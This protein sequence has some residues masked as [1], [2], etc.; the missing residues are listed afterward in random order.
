MRVVAF[1][2]SPRKEG[3]TALALGTV[4]AELEAAGI[5][6]ELVQVGGRRV[7]GCRA[8][9]RCWERRDG[10]CAVANDPVNG[11]IAKAVAADGILL[12]SPTYFSDV[13]AEMKAFIDRVGYV[14]KANGYLLRGKAGAAVASVARTGA[15]HAL[16]TMHHLFFN[17]QMFIPGAGY[18][19][20]VLG[21]NPGDVAQ[22]ATGMENLR[23]LGRNMALL[24]KA[25]DA[26]RRGEPGREKS[27]P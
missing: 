9:S 21:R 17:A 24:L 10:R 6:T 7:A 27:R 19:N 14:C 23:D 16:D 13:S 5:A 18:M 11:W 12:G 3:N 1:N 20:C 22:D 15:V 8:C 26:W 4:L 25:L 2:G